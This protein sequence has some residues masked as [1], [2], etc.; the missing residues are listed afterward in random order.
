MVFTRQWQALPSPLATSSSRKSPL[1]C[2]CLTLRTISS[3]TP[4][5][6]LVNDSIPFKRV[7]LADPESGSLRPLAPLKTI[8]DSIDPRTH[9]VELVADAPDP[10]VKI[11]DTKEAREKYKEA[12]K[13]AQAAAR[14]QVRKEIQVTWGVAAGDLAH[15]LEKVRQELVGGRKVDLIFASKKGQVVPTKQAM[16]TRLKGVLEGLADVGMEYL[17][18]EERKDMTALHLKPL[19]QS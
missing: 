15:K 6:R 5:K 17:P 4:T 14:A 19:S 16:D 10:I 9:H 1:A 7:R 8:L 3:S 12:K 11:I 2:Q 18:R 13:R